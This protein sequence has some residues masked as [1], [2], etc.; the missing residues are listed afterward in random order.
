MLEHTL[1]LSGETVDTGSVWQGWPA[2]KKFF[3]E[4]YRID[5]RRA[6]TKAF[7]KRLS[8]TLTGSTRRSSKSSD[9]NVRT[10]ETTDSYLVPLLED[11]RN[12]V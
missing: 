6:L 7:F 3:L 4:D 11:H 9:L 1:V 2:E 10:P 5:I 12:F 8:T